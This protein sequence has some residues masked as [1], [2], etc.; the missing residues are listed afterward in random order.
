ME[1]KLAVGGSNGLQQFPMVLMETI[2][3]NRQVN[4]ES[5]EIKSQ[6]NPRVFTQNLINSSA[7]GSASG[8][9][10]VSSGFQC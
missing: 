4:S 2:E 9:C 6:V 10:G 5:I 8:Y 3:V 1:R 7:L